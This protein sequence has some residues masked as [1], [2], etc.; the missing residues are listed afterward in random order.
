M[1]FLKGKILFLANR[2]IPSLL[3]QSIEQPRKMNR[4]NPFYL[5]SLFCGVAF[6]LSVLSFSLIGGEVV[7][8][9]KEE[10]VR[11]IALQDHVQ[12]RSTK[13]EDKNAQFA[14]YFIEVNSFAESNHLRLRFMTNL[15]AVVIKA[16]LPNP[17]DYKSFNSQLGKIKGRLFQA[18]IIS[19]SDKEAKV[20][21]E[22]TSGLLG[23]ESFVYTLRLKDG[24]WII[25]ER[26]VDAY[27]RIRPAPPSADRE[28]AERGLPS[29][30]V[31]KWGTT[32]ES[33]V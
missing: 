9:T 20:R 16:P 5:F 22:A 24:A 4:S 15:Q 8:L 19:F 28:I 32:S 30:R 33:R 31:R 25:V 21:T 3:M 12:M 7:Q 6:H 26:K 14:V 29:A 1:R 18:K 2:V 10:S 23:A 11:A 17:G 13:V 27:S